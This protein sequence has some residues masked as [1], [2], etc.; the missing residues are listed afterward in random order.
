MSARW[1]I[2]AA[3]L[4]LSSAALAQDLPT[5]S[6]LAD[7]FEYALVAGDGRP[8]PRADGFRYTENGATLDIWDGMWRTLSAVAGTDPAKYPRAAS[9]DYRVEIV[10]GDQ[11]VRLV[12]VDENTVQ[13]V[14]VLRLKVAGG[15]IAEAEVLPIREEFT[16]A[17][18]GTVG[19]FVPAVPVT[20]DGAKVGAPDPLF[21]TRQRVG[22]PASGDA[23]FAALLPGEPLTPE[24]QAAR[25]ALIDRA[26][27]YFRA[28]LA[29]DSTLAQ[30]A[31]DCRR[32]DNGVRTTNSSQAAPLD[33]ARPAYKPFALGCAGQ[34]DGGYFSNFKRI[35]GVRWFASTQRGVVMALVQLDQPGTVLGFDAPGVGKVAYP[36]PRGGAASPVP[37]D[38]ADEGHPAPNMITPLTVS[39]AFLFRIDTTGIR[40]IDAFY[41]AAPYGWTSGW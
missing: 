16:G 22:I 24:Q 1:W 10:D 14:M 11:V 17:R 33:P 4:A 3:A 34:I 6:Q 37:T 20:M 23:Y 18:S 19:L 36:G 9:L 28:L 41:R 30:F 12:E 29:G 8:L 32:N 5:P 27:G 21:R 31:P 2:G 40:R 7:Q 39:G 26:D 25:Q 38:G 15:K 35:R 13:G